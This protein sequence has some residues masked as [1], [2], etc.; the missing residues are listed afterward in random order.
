MNDQ[1][2]ILHCY[3]RTPIDKITH[4]L[5]VHPHFEY[6]VQPLEDLVAASA[7]DSH[8][9]YCWDAVTFTLKNGQATYMLNTDQTI[10][11]L[12][13][14]GPSRE[15]F[16]VGYAVDADEIVHPNQAQYKGWLDITM[17]ADEELAFGELA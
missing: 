17:K 5:P 3:R 8:Y 9:N 1:S 4:S 16:Q 11:I 13:R 6:V 14:G 15:S 12:K 2:M 7:A 10:S